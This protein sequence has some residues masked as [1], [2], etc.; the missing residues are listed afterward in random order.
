MQEIKWIQPG[1]GKCEYF[2]R[3]GY[4]Y[5]ITQKSADGWWH[6]ER[7]NM[8]RGEGYYAKTVCKTYK[9]LYSKLLGHEPPLNACNK[10]KTEKDLEIEIRLFTKDRGSYNTRLFIKDDKHWY[11]VNLQEKS[12]WQVITD[13]DNEIASP[14]F[15]YIPELK[16]WAA[17]NLAPEDAQITIYDFLSE[18]II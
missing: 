11:A 10:A 12:L 1:N 5:F 15:Q 17:Q 16:A 7:R 3:D 4:R 18:Q 13:R 9:Q 14:E 2:E 8:H 6:I